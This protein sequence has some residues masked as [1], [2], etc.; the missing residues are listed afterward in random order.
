M[1]SQKD[2]NIS[3]FSK[4]KEINESDRGLLREP[5]TKYYLIENI[6]VNKIFRKNASSIPRSPE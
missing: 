4:K 3:D 6:I 2:S 1:H 5:V